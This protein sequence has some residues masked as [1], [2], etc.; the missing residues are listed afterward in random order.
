MLLAVLD[1]YIKQH[2]HLQGSR[3]TPQLTAPCTQH[4]TPKSLRS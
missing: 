4:L 1:L 3:C 2:V